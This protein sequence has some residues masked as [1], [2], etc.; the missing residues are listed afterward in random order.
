MRLS[1]DQPIPD[2]KLFCDVKE[3]DDRTDDLGAR[4]QLPVLME[5]V[6][7]I[8]HSSESVRVCDPKERKD[9]ETHTVVRLLI[10]W[11]F[12]VLGATG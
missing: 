3:P 5:T 4:S 8:F 12:L 7:G 10:N 1:S 11:L 6:S 9:G 2:R